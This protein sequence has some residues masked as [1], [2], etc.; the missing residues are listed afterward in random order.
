MV[1]HLQC[2]LMSTCICMK[3]HIPVIMTYIPN[4]S[5]KI[6]AVYFNRHVG[7]DPHT[8]AFDVT[9]S[10]TFIIL[11]LYACLL[12]TTVTLDV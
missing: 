2:L 8:G 4:H 10:Y 7:W 5:L 3:F 9:V 11:D 1:T 6:I 12:H